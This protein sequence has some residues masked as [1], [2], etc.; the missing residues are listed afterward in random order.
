M[1][2]GFLGAGTISDAVVRGFVKGNVGLSSV[3]MLS[4]GHDFAESLK[5]DFSIVKITDD[6]Q[7]VVD[8]SD[9]IFVAVPG[10]FCEEVLKPLH[11]KPHQKLIVFVPTVSKAEVEAWTKNAVPVVRMLPLPFMAE[12]LTMTPIYPDDKE[13]AAML[14]KAG[15]HI[16]AKAEKDFNI[17][18]AGASFMGVYYRFCA[19]LN[20][21][22][23]KEGLDKEA[24]M[25][26]LTHV[27]AA[28]ANEAKTP[29]NGKYPTFAELE[30]EYSTKGGTNEFIAVEFGKNGG[31]DALLKAV[32]D[33]FKQMNK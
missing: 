22:A 17:F 16:V 27:F 15:G 12:H 24:S 25:A 20:D 26:Y 6:A 5:K 10:R 28:L 21:W 7:Y 31:T 9:W 19:V 11:F 14:D 18:M 29:R 1:K 33:G 13:L 23:D 30:T 3:T 4:K 2:I 8:N 32:Q